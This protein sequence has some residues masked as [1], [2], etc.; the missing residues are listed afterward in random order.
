M[1]VKP[2]KEDHPLKEF[3]RD[4]YPTY[5]RVNRIFTFGQ[6]RA[7]RRKAA[8]ECLEDQPVEVLDVCTGTG[9]F[10]IEMASMAHGQTRFTGY[11]FSAP[12]LDEAQRKL[13]AAGNKDLSERTR[14]M[15]GDVARMPFSDGEFDAV[16]ITFGI[17]NLIFENS[18]ADRHLAEIRRVLRKGG[19]LVILESSRPSFGPWRMINSL[20]LKF[21]LPYLGGWISGNLEAYRYLSRSSK[22]YY[23]I[24]E[25]EMILKGAGF[26]T[27]R[28]SPLFLGSVMLV[29]AQT[30]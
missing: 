22:N 27:V 4:I 3:Y 21:I 30:S 14:L 15:E 7:W 24:G 28:S 2:H 29:V 6:D 26:L 13:N 11:D 16:G 10:L 18:K 25:M 23:T 19:R 20:Y 17:R 1:T 9:D 12:M 8:R 5:D